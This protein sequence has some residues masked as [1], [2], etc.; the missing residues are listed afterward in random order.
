MAA[1]SS[2]TEQP[3]VAAADAEQPPE[4]TGSTPTDTGSVASRIE[5]NDEVQMVCSPSAVMAVTVLTKDRKA[6]ATNKSAL[7]PV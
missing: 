3:P 1:P 6:S 2:I 5:R 7:S 4:A